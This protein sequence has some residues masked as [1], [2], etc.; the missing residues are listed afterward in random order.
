VVLAGLLAA[1]GGCQENTSD[2]AA[3]SSGQPPAATS[4]S[5]QGPE[6]QQYQIPA[7][8]EICATAKRA[9]LKVNKAE[10]DADT[11]RYQEGCR[12]GTGEEKQ[13]ATV[14]VTFEVSPI[15]AQSFQNQKNDDWNKGFA[16]SGPA[17]DK[18]VVQQVG[19]ARMGQ[20][21]DDA[22]YAFFP[23]VKVAGT[24]NSKTKLVILRGN[25]SVT[26][27]VEGAEWH[28]AKPK[29]V[30]G[31]TPL[32]PKFGKDVIDKLADAVLALLKPE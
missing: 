17:R 28:G 8:D 3:S 4:A 14:T 10:K 27:S 32:E 20:D 26:F 19:H 16:F 12:I 11:P 15:A 2:G 24:T 7:W 13:I 6:P 21:Y 31:L 23:A 18:E 25:A 29:T 9:G 30:Q 22:Y 1:T 5:S